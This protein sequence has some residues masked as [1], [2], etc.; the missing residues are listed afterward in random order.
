[1]K[2][3][4]FFPAALL[5][6]TIACA[7][8]T[9]SPQN[10]APSTPAPA[11]QLKVR[12]PEAVTQ[13]DPNHIVATINGKQITARQA[14][15]MLKALSPEQRTRFEKNLSQVVQ[16]I[17]MT[18]QLAAAATQSHLDN[19]SPWK[20]QIELTRD[21]ILAQAY[22][23]TIEKNSSAGAPQDPKQYYDAH[24]SDFDQVKL[25]G[26]LVSFN[27][28][29]TPA[30]ATPGGARTEEAARQ[31]A[32]DVEKKLQ[33]GTDFSTLART[34]SDN[35]QI[36]AKGGDLGTHTLGGGDLPPDMK[37]AIEKLQ[38]GQFS[39]PVRLPNA[40]LIVK[41]DSRSKVSFDQARAGIV[42][43][44]QTEKNQAAVKQEMEKYKIQ[45]TDPAFFDA[46][47]APAPNLPS[48]QR[49][50]SPGQT[51]PPASQPQGHR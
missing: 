2:S 17:Y 30:S 9:S 44:L 5:C 21:Q 15:D 20:E 48:L 31:K 36:A 40:F 41:L 10:A 34:E 12:G 43:R 7:Q 35:Q 26:I 27:P 47:S 1:M 42:Q 11:S 6:A 24:P 51:A 22:L 50:P 19:Q 23:A 45:V 8:G 38:P 29:G 18:Q 13:Q 4:I 25:S 33:A 46:S 32:D 49:P 14:M 39:P 37:T 16:Q 28:P 3:G